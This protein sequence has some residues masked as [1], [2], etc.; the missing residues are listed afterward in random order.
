MA[1]H[2]RNRSWAPAPQALEFPTID[3][4]THV[5]SVVPFAAE[6]NRQAA[7]REQPA[8]P[9]Y[10]VDEI[11]DQAAAVG[12]AGIVDVGCEYPHLQAAVDM[13]KA[14][15]GTVHAGLAIHPNEAVLHGH[16]GA[17]GPDGLELAYQPW[18]DVPFDD[19]LAEVER[20]ARQNPHEVVAIGETGMDLFRT[21]QEAEELQRQAFRAHI[22]LAKELNLPMQIHD[23]DAHQQVIETLLADGSP[24]GTVFH[25]FSGGPEMARLANEHG[26]YLSFSG[27]V[28][29][30]GNDDIRE[31][32]RIV[33]KGHVMVETD[34]PYLSPMP[35][36]GR[37][38]AP[39]M[40]PYTLA[41]MADTLG[42]S[43]QKVAEMTRRTAKMVY[44]I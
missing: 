44:G 20:L 6:M 2:H 25:S 17:K 19:A 7:A 41:S 31:A 42:M 39:Y 10:S 33:D 32:L 27:T 15:P 38:N 8:V 35:Y 1:K 37:T 11:L 24:E 16:H 43:V 28:S 4:H 13:A 22:A 3:N 36:R 30:K 9:V 18:H 21:G 34:A 29:Y 14:H 12:V 23:R 26:W 40:I 5:A